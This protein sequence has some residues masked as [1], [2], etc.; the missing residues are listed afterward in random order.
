MRFFKCLIALAVVLTADPGIAEK[1]PPSRAEQKL[2]G[3]TLDIVDLSPR[4]LDFYEASKSLHPDRRFEEWQ[5]RYGFAAVPPTAEGMSIARNLLD[6][7]WPKYPAI[8]P[9]AKGGFEGMQPS[10]VEAAAEV[11]DLLKADRPIKLKLV[12]YVG[13]FEDNA[14]VSV[15]PDGTP[16]VALPLEMSPDVRARVLRHELTHAI[17]AKTAKLAPGYERSLA[18]VIFEEGLAMHVARSLTTGA[19]AELFGEHRPGWLAEANA[20]RDGILRGIRPHLKTADGKSVFAFTM[21]R[22]SQ[23]MEREAYFVGWQVV[24]ELLRNGYSFEQLARVAEADMPRIVDAT[25]AR[26]LEDSGNASGSEADSGN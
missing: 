5:K 23:D 10:P 17:H 4:F 3:I 19:S 21:G 13:G 14:F 24:G 6:S 11:A 1:V 26:L 22:G 15:E 16:F 12:V 18:R 9:I 7:A 8:L 2:G 25:I 20:R